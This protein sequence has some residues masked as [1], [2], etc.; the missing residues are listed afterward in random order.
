MLNHVPVQVNHASVATEIEA[1]YPSAW[2][3][4]QRHYLAINGQYAGCM[5]V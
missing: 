4:Y 3:S 5:T 2:A 1:L